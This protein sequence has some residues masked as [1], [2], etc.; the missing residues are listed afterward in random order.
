MKEAIKDTFK[1]CYNYLYQKLPKERIDEIV[2]SVF[3]KDGNDYGMGTIHYIYAALTEEERKYL[4]YCN[5]NYFIN[6]FIVPHKQIYE[7][8]LQ[9]VRNGK[10]QTH[11]MWYIFPQMKGLGK[12]D[13]SQL[14]GIPDRHQA[15]LYLKHPVLGNHLREITQAVLDNEKSPYEIFGTDVIKFRS[16]MLLFAS[17]ENDSNVFKQILNKNCWC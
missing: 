7:Q 17:L 5:N 4:D 13:H 6:R 16:C 15:E 9:E 2:E 3:Q 1:I 11:W 8:A 12:S 14:Y 10:K